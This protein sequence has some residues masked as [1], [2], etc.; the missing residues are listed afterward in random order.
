M[1]KLTRTCPPWWR[2]LRRL[3]E[4]PPTVGRATLEFRGSAFGSVAYPLVE[5]MLSHKLPVQGGLHGTPLQLLGDIDQSLLEIANW[6]R[7]RGHAAPWRNELI[8]VASIDGRR[9]GCVERAVVRNLGIATQ[10]VQLHG[11][12]EGTE[13]YWLQQRSFSK[14]T[15]PGR[16]DTLVGGLVSDG[17]T[18]AET[19]EREI[20]EEAGL[21]LE[22]MKDLQPCGSIRLSR[23]VEDSGNYGYLVET[24]FVHRCVVPAADTPHNQDGEVEQ[25]DQFTD[26]QI[27]TSVERGDITLEAAIAIALSQTS[28]SPAS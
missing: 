14:Q 22:S 5:Q 27:N 17:E 28:V 18:A 15:D 10:A 26:D 19:L 3:V 16:W 2:R 13:R 25:F 7:L 23:P 4:L 20:L 1:I 24:L 21:R 8:C 12:V 11:R 9:I 6:L